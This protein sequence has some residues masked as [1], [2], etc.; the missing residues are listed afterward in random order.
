MD[1]ITCSQYRNQPPLHNLPATFFTPIFA[2]HQESHRY[3]R[4]NPVGFTSSRECSQGATLLLV[5][6]VSIERRQ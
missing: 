2:F 1:R 5:S 3:D 6:A 4:R